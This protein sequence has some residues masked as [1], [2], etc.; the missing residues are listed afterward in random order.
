MANDIKIALFEDTEHTR[1]EILQALR[2][3]LGDEGSVV[4]FAAEHFQETSGEEGRTYEDRLENILKKSPYDDT[5]LIVADR[6]LSKSE[7][8]GGLSVNSVAA[9]A[10]RLAIPVCAYARAFRPDDDYLWRGRWE[11]GLIVLSL[12]EGESELA[13]RAVLAA[14]GFANIGEKLSSV[15]L[16][17]NSSPAKLLAALLAHTEEASKIALYAVGDQNRLTELPREGQ[18]LTELPRQGEEWLEWVKKVTHFLGYWL[19]DSLLRYPGVF[20]NEVAT[21]SHLNIKTEDFRRDDVK[22][23]FT[24]AIYEGPFADV[25]DPQWWRGALDDIV[26]SENCADGLEL[27]RGK[28]DENISRSE[29]S[30]D[31]E[32]SAGYYCIISSQPVSLQNSKGNLSW[33][34]RGA[35]LTRV[36]NPKFDEYGPWLGT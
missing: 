23:M 6:D 5:T 17:S 2:D 19:H 1:S 8:F 35:D 32:I 36:S 31:P 22:A 10:R 11:E 7:R 20:A 29:C 14:H 4:P 26:A 25:N 30:V 12:S 27:V 3:R 34:P 28:I 9:A 15:D 24:G 21:A 16:E 33:F 13:R 18:Q